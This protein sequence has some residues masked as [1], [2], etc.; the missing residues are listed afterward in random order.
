MKKIIFNIVSSLVFVL[1]MGGT[2]MILIPIKLTTLN[3][4]FT[5]GFGYARYL[6][7]IP[8]LIGI[9]IFFF[10]IKDFIFK[11]KG[12]PAPYHPP[13]ELVAN[14]LY[15]F[16]RNPIYVGVLFVLFGEILL[17]ESFILLFYSCL[18]FLIFHIFVITFEEPYLKSNFGNSYENYCNSVP[19]WLIRLKFK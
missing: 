16:T 5:F 13:K 2:V 7:V 10:C 19:R 17:F 8:V 6:G 12:T 18:I 14:G 9:S 4:R 3:G 1:L 15:K 11:G